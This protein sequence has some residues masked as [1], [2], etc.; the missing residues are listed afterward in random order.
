MRVLRVKT[1][2]KAITNERNAK[3]S[4]GPRSPEGLA[5][6]SQNATR[7]GATSR[8]P[9]E[10]IDGARKLLRLNETGVRNSIAMD[11]LAAALAETEQII[12]ARAKLFLALYD[13]QFSENP[14]YFEAGLLAEIDDVINDELLSDPNYFKSVNHFRDLKFKLRME[15]R[16]MSPIFMRQLKLNDRYLDEAQSRRRTAIRSIIGSGKKASAPIY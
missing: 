12:E 7:H 16:M 6:S 14:S 2:K 10:K 1:S 4:T 3:K 9:D 15:A 8:V 13:W 5:R 11:K